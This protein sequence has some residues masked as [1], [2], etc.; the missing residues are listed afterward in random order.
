MPENLWPLLTFLYYTGVRI[1]EARQIMWQ[2]DGTRQVNL[3][4]KEIPLLGTQTKNGKPRMLPLS[5]ELG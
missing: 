3:R 2:L 1:G 5:D 4:K